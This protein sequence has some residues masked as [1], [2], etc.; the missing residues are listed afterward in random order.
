MRHLTSGINRYVGRLDLPELGTTLHD[1]INGQCT[2]PE[3]LG[4]L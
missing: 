2:A 1:L 3:E 4:T